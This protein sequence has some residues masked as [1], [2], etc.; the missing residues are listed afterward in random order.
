MIGAHVDGCS[1]DASEIVPLVSHQL[2]AHVPEEG[3]QWREVQD[4][5]GEGVEEADGGVVV[6]LE[7]EDAVDGVEDAVVP[8]ERE[9]DADE[10]AG[11]E[12]EEADEAA[13]LAVARV[14]AV[15]LGEQHPPPRVESPVYDAAAAR[16]GRAGPPVGAD[17]AE[18]DVV[19]QVAVAGQHPPRDQL[20]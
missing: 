16:A 9:V 15:A 19:Q 2:G 4:V 17:G 1:T 8:E 11:G 12:V 14:E 3:L 18:A 6:A 7:E 5:A 13:Q 20:Q 10:G